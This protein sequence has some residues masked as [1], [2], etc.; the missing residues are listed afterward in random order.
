MKNAIV[1]IDEGHNILEMAQEGS[2]YEITTKML[3][4]A[5]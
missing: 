1:I 4:E 5:E 2:S 3:E